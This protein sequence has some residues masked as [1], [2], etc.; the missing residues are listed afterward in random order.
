MIDPVTTVGL[1]ASIVQI[2]RFAEHVYDEIKELHKSKSGMTERTQQS[3]HL[4]EAMRE[5]SRRINAFDNK[6]LD[7][8]DTALAALATECYKLCE[9]VIDIS[10]KFIYRDKK[11]IVRSFWHFCK[12]RKYERE[13]LKLE[14]KLAECRDLLNSYLFYV[15]RYVIQ[16]NLTTIN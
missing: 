13:K 7:E 11:S 16:Q 3:L 2:V 1:V 4:A 9:K 10:E 14:K 8:D 5:L 12:T 6:P 15:S